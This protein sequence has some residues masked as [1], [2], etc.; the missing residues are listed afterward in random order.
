[1]N[2]SDNK[3]FDAINA[4]IIAPIFFFLGV[5]MFVLT[6]TAIRESGHNP[7]DIVLGCLMFVLGY[8]A[9]RAGKKLKGGDCGSTGGGCH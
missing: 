7:H 2:S 4:T 1:M 6:W 3:L 8:N 5:V 9:I